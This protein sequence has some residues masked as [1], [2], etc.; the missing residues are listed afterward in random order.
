MDIFTS[1]AGLAIVRY[2]LKNSIGMAAL[3]IQ[4]SMLA[5]QFEGKSAVVKRKRGP[6]RGG[7]TV[8]A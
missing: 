4:R 3:T 1:M 7:V 6:I 2:A 5:R 8:A